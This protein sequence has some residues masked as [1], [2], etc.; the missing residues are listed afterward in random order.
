MK[1]VSYKNT[2]PY[3]RTSHKGAPYLLGDAY[4]NHGELC[5]SIAKWVRGLYTPVNPATSFDKDSDIPE[6]KASVKS[7]HCS[8]ARKLFG[9]TLGEQVE[10]FI[11]R[12]HSDWFVWVEWNEKTEHV[13]EYWMNHDEFAKFCDKFVR[14]D[15]SSKIRP[16]CMNS[17]SKMRAWLDSHTTEWVMA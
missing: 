10:D 7:S 11:N 6:L 9:E 12:S 1:R 3:T 5:E 8:L 13:D 14:N 4:K 2:L 17:S 15:S 16:R